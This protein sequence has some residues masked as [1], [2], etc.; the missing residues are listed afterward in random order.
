VNGATEQASPSAEH[1]PPAEHAFFFGSGA[2]L[3]GVYHGPERRRGNRA[4]LVCYPIGE[5]VMRTFGAVRMVTNRLLLAGL[6]VQR[7]DYYGQGD[8]GGGNADWSIETWTDNVVAAAAELRRRAGVGEISVIGIRLG[9][10][11]AGLALERGLAVRDAVLWDPVVSGVD[12]LRSLERMQ[13]RILD[14]NAEHFPYPTAE[15]LDVDPYELCG[16]RF[17][18]SFRRELGDVVLTGRSFAGC[19]RVGICVSNDEP[20][21]RGLEASIRAAGRPVDYRVAADNVGDWVDV[22]HFEMARLPS[23]TLENIV[24]FLKERAS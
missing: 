6:P 4:V 18:P 19:R 13:V 17:S 3:Y 5:E 2:K 8:S 15:D 14:K 24:K 10:A 22:D 23:A 11:I 12:Y 16:F 7:F 9:A 1:S 21:Y 20:D